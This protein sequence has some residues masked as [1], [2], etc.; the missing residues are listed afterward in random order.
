M[1][2]LDG[3]DGTSVRARH[4][5]GFKREKGGTKVVEGTGAVC[6]VKQRVRLEQMI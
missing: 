2:W 6:G 3:D 4:W 5:A 1:G